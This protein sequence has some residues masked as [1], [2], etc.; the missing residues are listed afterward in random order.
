MRKVI[1]ALRLSRQA[2]PLFTAVFVTLTL[3]TAPM[4]V[5]TAWLTK[6]VL[7]DITA[8]AGP[9]EVLGKGVA[10]AA[11][12]V[13]TGLIPHISQYAS[14]ETER[15]VGLLA[16]ERLFLATE[17]FVGMARFEDPV[18]LNRMQMAL[19]HGGTTPGVVVSAALSIVGSVVGG[20]GFLGALTVIS[21]WMPVVITASVLP[22][23]AVELWLARG[24]AGLSWRLS[25]VERR[26]MFFRDLLTST[27]AAKEIRL[28]GIGAHLR[29]R[30]TEQRRLSNKENR[31][32]D[33]RQVGAQSLIGV[34]GTAVAGGALLWAVLAAAGG[35]IGIG[36][37]SLMVASVAGVQNA[38]VSLVHTI[39]QCHQQLLLFEHYLQVVT[40]GPDLPVARSPRAIAPLAGGIV[41]RDVW[42]RYSPDHPWALR[43]LDLTIPHGRTVG[44]VGRNGAGK[45]T[46][47]KLLCRMYDPERGAILWDGVDLRE[48]D[49]AALRARIGVVFQ[50]YME[51]DLS[52]AENIGLGALEHLHDRERVTVA[53]AGAGAHGFVGRLPRSYDTLLSRLFFQGDDAVEGGADAVGVTLSGGQ[54]QRLALAR[55]HLRAERDLM[56]LDEPSSGLD[57]E[58]E[59]EIHRGLRRRRAG[60]TNVLISHRLNTVREADLLVVLD[61]GT[62]VEQGTHEEL[63]ARGGLYADLFSMQA[64]GYAE[65]VAEQVRR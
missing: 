60:R 55:A 65:A 14:R 42:F 59:H 45:S 4:P 18:F 23:L 58:A 2:S 31:R 62:A 25:P 17:R 11:A 51:Y 30:M 43:G 64:E 15:R 21:P 7:D 10:L 47:I 49:P 27:Q 16:Q 40:A 9:G 50:D 38:G 19:R 32:L 44:L 8:G 61:E 46:L 33:H 24:R 13:V 1:I 41:F 35:R 57:A 37:V 53:A 26:E 54:W 3:L 28:F 20:L 39:A 5:V 22:V 34:G 29:E 56:I 36:D 52:A 6:V 12:G 63:T 48:L